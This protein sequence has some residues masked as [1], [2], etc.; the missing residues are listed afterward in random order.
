MFIVASDV[1]IALAVPSLP[2]RA[3]AHHLHRTTD[4]SLLALRGLGTLDHH[5]YA[6]PP[7]VRRFRHRL[8]TV[9]TR[10]PSPELRL[11]ND[12]L[13]TSDFTVF[14]NKGL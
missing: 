10:R 1:I 7:S 8:G 3:R 6:T 9:L 5:V 13:T 4:G 11:T 14:F 12:I 2:P